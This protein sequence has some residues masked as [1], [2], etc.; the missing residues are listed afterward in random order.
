MR[1]A[2]GGGW[3][4]R[5][6]PGSG[7]GEPGLGAEPCA[8]MDSSCCSTG[9][10][11]PAGTGSQV[12]RELRRGPA[13][14]QQSQEQP[15]ELGRQD[16]ARLKWKGSSGHGSAKQRAGCP[17]NGEL[18]GQRGTLLARS[19]WHPRAAFPDTTL[20]PAA[21]WCVSLVPGPSLHPISSLQRCPTARGSGIAGEGHDL[22][23][24]V[25]KEQ[26]AGTCSL[27]ICTGLRVS[28]CSCIS[29]SPPAPWKL[30]MC[31]SETLRSRAQRDSNKDLTSQ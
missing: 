18:A 10:T 20:G 21:V 3:S 2:A 14:H 24:R 19:G 26:Q 25:R 16:G 13:R 15:L 4:R 1:G 29:P 22:A 11:P 23:G 12:W 9:A 27:G 8:A 17:G 28:A 5:C 6:T 30:P 7:K 31:S